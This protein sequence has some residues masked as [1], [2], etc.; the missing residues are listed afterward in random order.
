MLQDAHR[1]C[2]RHGMAGMRTKIECNLANVALACGN[3]SQA[4]DHARAAHKLA[5]RTGQ[6]SVAAEASYILAAAALRLGDLPTARR[7]LAVG[8]TTAIAIDRRDQLAV[9]V[10][11]FAEVLAAQGDV[12]VAARTMAF[13]LRQHRFEGE[14]YADARRRMASWG[15][16]SEET[17]DW[18]GPPLDELAYRIVTEAAQGYAPL[19]ASL[20]GR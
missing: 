3:N 12:D 6:R 14:A 5:E 7:E 10:R 4:S 8:L 18:I 15:R 13:A 11:A 19:I 17:D 9:G 2:D 1:L 20:R 16:S